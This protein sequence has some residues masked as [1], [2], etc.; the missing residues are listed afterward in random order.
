MREREREE[1]ERYK[2]SL[3]DLSYTFMCV[4]TLVQ[5][6]IILMASACKFIP[7]LSL[8]L[9]SPALVMS[10]KNLD[11]WE[12]EIILGKFT[13]VWT[14]Y[15][16]PLLGNSGVKT[17]SNLREELLRLEQVL[18]DTKTVS[19]ES[20]LYYSHRFFYVL[21][22]SCSMCFHKYLI[23]YFLYIIVKIPFE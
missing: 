21:P 5:L 10:N 3:W 18:E 4:F 1:E 2:W 11:L 15:C 14:I 22:M 8:L 7:F 19:S 6:L 17:N 9:L 12:N 13:D 20:P 23:L 16:Q